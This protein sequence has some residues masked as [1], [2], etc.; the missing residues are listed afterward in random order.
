MAE[1]ARGRRRGGRRP[2]GQGGPAAAR[3]RAGAPR[4]ELAGIDS[5]SVAIVSLR[6]RRAVDARPAAAACWSSA[7][8]RLAVKGVDVLEQ[9]VAARRRTA[10]CCCAP[11]SAGRGSRRPCSSTTPSWSRWCGASCARSPGIAAAPVDARVT[12]WGGGLPQY[13]VAT[14]SAWRASAAAVDAVPG[15]AMCGA[16]F[17]GVG[18]PA[19]IAA[20]RAAVDMVASQTTPR[21]PSEENERMCHWQSRRQDR[22]RDQRDGPLHR[23]VGVPQRAP[24]RRRRPQPA[25]GRGRAADR[26]ARRQGRRGARHLRRLRAARRRRPDDL[27]AR[28]DGRRA[29]GGL[30]PVPPHPAGRPPGTDVVE[31]GAAPPGRV[32]QEPRPGVPRRRDPEGLRLRLPVR[33]LL[34]VVPAARRRA[35]RPAGRARAAGSR[36]PRRARQ[37]G[38]VV[39]ARRL[40]V[41]PRLRGRRAAPDR[42][43]DAASARRRRPAATSG[44]RSRSTPAAAAASRSWSKPCPDV[45]PQAPLAAI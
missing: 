11:R 37:H 42:R 20:A 1:R 31:H 23:V 9:Q 33:P 45:R 28:T 35:A 3:G 26:R 2:A 16:A 7:G 15:L 19:C 29:A 30:L 5:A 13:A 12:R 10:G 44:W 8:E 39:R 38:L 6:L 4:T 27:V 22:T 24:P 17:D 18:V 34:R 40:R 25:R 43:P 36:L 41:D 32:Q 21:C 14:S